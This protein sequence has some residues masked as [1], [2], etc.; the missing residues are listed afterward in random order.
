MIDLSGIFPPIPTPFDPAGDLEIARF[1]QN[2]IHL[3]QFDLAG[4]LVLGS[5]GEPVMVSHQEKTLIFEAARKAIPSSK[6]MLAGTGGQSTR[7]TI[8]LTHSAAQSGADAA[9]ILN[10]FFYKGLMTRD[11]LV[12]HYYLT[13]DQSAIPVIIYNMPANTGIDMN[14]ET[15]LEISE[16]PNIIGLKDSGGNLAKMGE[17]IARA[18]PGFQVLAGSAG[19]LFPALTIGA[20][21]GILALANIVPQSCIDLHKLYLSGEV[22]KARLLQLSLIRLNN[23]VTREHGVPALKAAMDHLDLYGGPCREP[24]MPLAASVKEQVISLLQALK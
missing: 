15:I 20:A 3:S 9:V 1:Q 18:K 14:A 19:F 11:A 16:H 4:F 5:N 8:E 6:L 17:I 24:V 21:G 10:P 13:A 23:M 22:E 2:L 7:E 12:R